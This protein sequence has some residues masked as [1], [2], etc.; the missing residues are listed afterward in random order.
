[1]EEVRG[2]EGNMKE[3]MRGGLRGGGCEGTVTWRRM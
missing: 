1:M 2:G 3:D